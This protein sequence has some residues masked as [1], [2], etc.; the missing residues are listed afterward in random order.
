[1]NKDF[2]LFNLKEARDQIV[3]TIQNMESDPEYEYGNYVVEI[4]HL[5]HHLNTAWNARDS[6]DAQAKE[7]SE[8]DWDKWRQFPSSDEI[9][10][11]P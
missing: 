7:C 9:Y 11:G 10:L 3:Q 1:M 2:I 5:Y 8:A 4:T 6:S